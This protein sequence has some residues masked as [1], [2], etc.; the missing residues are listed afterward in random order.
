MSVIAARKRTASV[1]HV[2]RIFTPQEPRHAALADVVVMIAPHT[3]QTDNMLGAA[4][5]A[6]M[7]YGA[8]SSTSAVVPPST[9]RR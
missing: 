7:R 1:P 8:S 9:S 3:P 6:A 4:E 2:D 5:F